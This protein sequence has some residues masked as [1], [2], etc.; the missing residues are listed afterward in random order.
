MWCGH[1][2]QPAAS[3]H[4]HFPSMATVDPA[5]LN[6]DPADPLH[7]SRVLHWISENL[8]HDSQALREDARHLVDHSR[9]LR[10]RL[11]AFMY[12]PPPRRTSAD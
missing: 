2:S 7:R 9:D 6:V 3:L 10:A 11:R 8:L 12:P 5:D 4:L 1:R